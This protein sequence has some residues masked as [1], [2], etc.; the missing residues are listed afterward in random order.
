MIRLSETKILEDYF[1]DENGIITDINGII[2]ETYLHQ[3]RPTFK[4]VAI[5]RIMMYTFYEYRDGKI[6][7]IHHIDKNPLNN[8]LKNL[9]YL[10]RA[11]HNNIHH[12]G[13]QYSIETKQ[14]MSLAKK[15]HVR[16]NQT[17]I[18]RKT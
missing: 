17:K 9:V 15:K 10:T 2:Q 14:K 6:W 12:K 5:Y 13:K 7:D 3:G 1:I 11:E 16:R 4:N 8:S 18:I